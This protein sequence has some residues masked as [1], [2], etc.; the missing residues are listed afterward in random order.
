MGLKNEKFKTT[1]LN[2]KFRVL[3][4]RFSLVTTELKYLKLLLTTLERYLLLHK[5]V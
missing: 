4:K 3:I 2:S 5:H 1:R